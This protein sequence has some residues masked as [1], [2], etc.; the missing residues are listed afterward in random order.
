MTATQFEPCLAGPPRDL[1]SEGLHVLFQQQVH[2][3]PDTAAVITTERVL[4]YWELAEAAERVSTALA[5]R[6]VVAG[7]LVGVLADR[8]LD[9]IVLMIAVSR[10]GAACLPLDPAYPRQRL[11]VMLADERLRCVVAVDGTG[12]EIAELADVVPFDDLVRGGSSRDSEHGDLLTVLY[13][14]G[15]SGTPKGVEITHR[16]VVRLVCDDE[17]IDFGSSDVVLHYAP[18]TFDAALLEVWGALTRGAT[19]AVAPPGP[20]TLDELAE[21]LVRHQVTVAWLTAG[22]FHQLVEFNPECFAGLRR[23]FAGGDVV[24]PRHVRTL[25]ELHPGLEFVNGYGPTESTTFTCCHLVRSADEL[26]GDTVPIGTPI[27]NTDVFVVGEDG[28]P[29]APGERGELWIAGDGLAAGYAGRPDLTAERFGTI[30][31]TR[32]YRTGDLV[33]QRPDGALE[34]LGRNDFQVKIN[35]F[36]IE[37]PEVEAALGALPGVHQACVLAEPD[38]FGG[39]RLVAFVVPDEVSGTTPRHL[40]AGLAAGLPSYMVPVRYEFMDRFP[41]TRNGKVDR[42]V[43][44]REQERN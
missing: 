15:S 1:P 2:R 36:R 12:T 3:H 18:A 17:F 4:S 32:V 29:V 39:K 37:L 38:P 25:L 26:S 11:A 34:F 13:T 14:S 31:D 35:G 10:T 5:D 9:A 20:L 42:A 41:L 28:T 40:R 33:A 6:G 27:A 30:G 23:V 22:V 44:L 8:G 21:F 19:I 24:S 7:D 43:L 16:G